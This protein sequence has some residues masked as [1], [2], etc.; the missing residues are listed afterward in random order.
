MGRVEQAIG[1][2]FP[3]DRSPLE[4]QRPADVR[5]DGP[6]EPHRGPSPALPGFPPPRPKGS[7]QL[8]LGLLTKATRVEPEED[9]VA[10]LS[11]GTI[12]AVYIHEWIYVG[13][14]QF[15]SIRTIV[16]VSIPRSNLDTEQKPK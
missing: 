13:G 5:K 11:Q 15:V 4:W 8:R 6:D 2:A 12:A 1:R 16:A 10:A 7:D 3:P 14:P 9:P